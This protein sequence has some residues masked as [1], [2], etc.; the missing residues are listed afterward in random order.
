MEEPCTP[1]RPSHSPAISALCAGRPGTAFDLAALRIAVFGALI[2]QTLLWQG[3]PSWFA[4]LPAALRVPPPGWR[5]VGGLPFATP[6]VVAVLEASFVVVCLLAA[7]GWFTRATSIV[8]TLLGLYLLGLPQSFGKLNHYHHLLWLAALLAASPCGDAW[9][10]DRARRGA[11]AEPAPHAAYCLPLRVTWVLVGLMYLF[12]GLWKILASP[13]GWF[14]GRDL[15]G[16]LHAKWH[17]LG[18]FRPLLPID[19]WPLLAR[20]LSWFTL[21]F[22]LGFL[23]LVLWRRTRP[24]VVGGGLLFHAG[25]TLTMRISFLPLVVCYVA[26]LDW[27]AIRSKLRRRI[28]RDA[29]G[30]EARPSLSVRPAAAVGAVLLCG[31]TL[32]GALGHDGWPFA[33]YPRFHYRPPT[34]VPVVRAERQIPGEAPEAVANPAFVDELH[35]SRWAAIARSLTSPVDTP[36]HTERVEALTRLYLDDGL[37]PPLRPCE[38]LMIF[39]DLDRTHPAAAEENPLRRHLVQ[40]T[41]R[42][43]PEG[44]TGEAAG[45]PRLPGDVPSP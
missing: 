31:A 40:V 34:V 11:V 24:Y 41:E 21:A 37:R 16:H 9:S 38:R 23:P 22:E 6:V 8:A 13:S 4:S 17:E 1:S 5:A 7:A 3:V 15:V 32:A 12:P 45:D 43:P 39:L 42:R 28:G 36:Q 2:A 29:P 33:V 14:S 19:Q 35:S 27:G 30:V 25:T 44:C 20:A 10:I 18:G 26:F